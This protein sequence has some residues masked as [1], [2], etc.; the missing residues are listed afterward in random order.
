[1]NILVTGGLG[2]IG[3]NI[4]HAMLEDGNDVVILD[5]LSRPGVEKNQVWLEMFDP[6]I[7]I[8]DV[9]DINDVRKAMKDVDVVFH[10]AG[11]VG[12]QTSIDKPMY[13]FDVNVRGTLNILEVARGMD[14]KPMII[15]AS[16][17]KV[18]GEF[19]A[20]SPISENQQLHFC[21][22]YGCSKGA[23]EQ[24]ILDYGKVYDF[25]TVVLR[26]SCIYGT[27]QFGIEE[28]GWLSHFTLSILRNE[29]ITIYGDGTQV[30]D[31]LFIDD[32]VALLK[33]LVENK[34]KVKGN[35]FNIGGGD[36]NKVSVNEAI[37][38]ISEDLGLPANVSFD[39]WRKSDQKY[40]VSD[41]KKVKS[42]IGWEPKISVSEG[43]K[44]LE[45]WSKEII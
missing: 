18:Y 41:I 15:F 6:K 36:K 29:P 33:L 16:T 17:N 34:D 11:Q 1:M 37:E 38:T 44:R 32:Y 14:K 21:T 25:P 4:A 31:V 30:R 12:V 3:S 13:D 5:N 24:Y 2:F 22:P 19:E 8:G 23:A 26:M 42:F 40:Y 39:E 35:A 28:Q 43:L 45:E 9:R 20:N 27:R 10:Y 7:I